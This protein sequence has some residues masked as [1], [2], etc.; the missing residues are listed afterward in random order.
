[1]R[2]KGQGVGALMDMKTSFTLSEAGAGTSMAWEADV[3][4]A[5][6]VGAMGQRVLQPIVNQQVTQVLEAL[7]TR[8]PLPPRRAGRSKGFTPPRP[9][10]TRPSRKG[11][12]T[13]RPSPDGNRSAASVSRRRHAADDGAARRDAR[14]GARHGSGRDGHDLARRGV[15]V[16]AQARDGG[17]LVDGRLRAHGARDRAAHDRLGDHLAVH[18]SSG[19]SCDGC[20][21]RAGGRRAGSVPPR[22]RDVEDLP[23]QHPLADLEDARPDARRGDDRP[24]RARRRAVLSTRATPGAP[25]CPA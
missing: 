7:E 11:R 23:Q 22:L 6:P 15:P 16:V 8:V 10:H 13:R 1:M 12:R 25:T 9:R 14:V 17:A 19:A 24:R 18:A 5:G 20:K 2:A 21:S 3:K 4:I